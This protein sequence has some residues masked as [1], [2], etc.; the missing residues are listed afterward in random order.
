MTYTHT[1]P[2]SKPSAGC[3]VFSKALSHAISLN[4]ICSWDIKL[5]MINR[6]G[7]IALILT[8]LLILTFSL[9]GQTVTSPPAATDPQDHKPASQSQDQTKPAPQN[10]PNAPSS[11]KPSL[12]DLGF[13]PEQVQANPKEQ[14]LLD[15]RTHM[16]KIHQ[17]LGFIT[18]FPMVATVVT[19]IGAGGRSTSRTSRDIHTALGAATGDLYFTSAYFAIRA[20]KVPGTQTRGQI[21]AHKALAWVHGPGMVL[22]P[23][24]GAIA[25]DQKSK[26]EKVHGIAQA[27]GPVAIVTAGAYGAAFMSVAFKF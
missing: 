3:I 17:K 1:I 23:I 16:L 8:F 14:A 5:M 10:L 20:P 24:L 22:T 9:F 25:F 19:S 15:K 11:S 18:L 6:R 26:G 27:H 7:T 12:G 13:P 4:Q 2:G 21:R